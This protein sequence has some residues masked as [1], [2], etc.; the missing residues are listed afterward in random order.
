M[1][2]LTPAQHRKVHQLLE[3]RAL[4]AA[5]NVFRVTM[6][7]DP[8]QVPDESMMEMCAEIAKVFYPILGRFVS[9]EPIAEQRTLPAAPIDDS[10]KLATLRALVSDVLT[11]PEEMMPQRVRESAQRVQDWLDKA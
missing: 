5:K 6:G 2:T 10:P 4:D 9:G 7:L 1:P 11:V 8:D 3:P